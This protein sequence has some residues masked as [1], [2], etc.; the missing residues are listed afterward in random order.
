MISF[1]V[2]NQSFTWEQSWP[3]YYMLDVYVECWSLEVVGVKLSHINHRV[4]SKLSDLS[5]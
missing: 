3:R 4:T 5:L 1:E 2:H